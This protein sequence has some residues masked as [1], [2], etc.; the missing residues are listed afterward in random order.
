MDN[1]LN[2]SRS[3]HSYQSI[4]II[5]HRRNNASP[6]TWT[7]KPAQCPMV[8]RLPTRHRQPDR[9]WL[10][11]RPTHRLLWIRRRTKALP[12]TKPGECCRSYF[13]SFARFNCKYVLS[14][15][16]CN[17]YFCFDSRTLGC[18]HIEVYAIWYLLYDL[19]SATDQIPLLP[20]YITWM[21]S[22][23]ESKSHS[24]Y[25][26]QYTPMWSQPYRRT[27]MMINIFTYGTDIITEHMSLG[28][29]QNMSEFI[30]KS[31]KTWSSSPCDN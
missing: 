23:A 11:V 22:V 5:N 10:S 27:I 14:D 21:S 26:I 20:L 13:F 30:I 4:K 18:D 16:K 17:C 31:N 9:T 24:E 29:I 25:R 12:A 7:R 2:R 3:V 6:T 19:L 1:L 28:F 15:F 8:T